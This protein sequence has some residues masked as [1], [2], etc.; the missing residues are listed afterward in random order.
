[1]EIRF[2][3]LPTMIIVLLLYGS[4]QFELGSSDRISFVLN[5]LFSVLLLNLGILCLKSYK[6][7]IMIN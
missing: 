2:I 4:Y 1:M 3:L 7:L 5:L 6:K